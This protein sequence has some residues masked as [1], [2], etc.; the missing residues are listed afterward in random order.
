M[1]YKLTA[2]EFSNL[3][4]NKTDISQQGLW[5]LFDWFESNDAGT[6]LS[7]KKVEDILS[8][9]IEWEVKEFC[10]FFELEQVAEFENNNYLI[11]EAYGRKL[12]STCGER[13]IMT[14]D[15]SEIVLSAFGIG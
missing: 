2:S 10:Q 6:V 3:F 12:F 8:S 13:R 14:I 7:A 4:K 11:I 5:H 1:Q 15:L 9:T